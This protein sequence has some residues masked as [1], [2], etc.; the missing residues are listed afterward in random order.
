M[1]E[2]GSGH[3]ERDVVARPT[4][5]LGALVRGVQWRRDLRLSPNV[6]GEGPDES[7][8]WTSAP[9]DEVARD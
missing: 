9:L 2:V 6:G 3:Q 8:Y 4:R 1:R 5:R 7:T